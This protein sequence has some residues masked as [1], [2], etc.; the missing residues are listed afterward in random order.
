MATEDAISSVSHRVARPRLPSRRALARAASSHAAEMGTM[1][2]E[3]SLVSVATKMNSVAQIAA[4][5]RLRLP[6]MIRVNGVTA[7]KISKIW[8]SSGF[9]RV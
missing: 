2:T 3:V 7:A 8:S 4:S 1:I 6:L 5:T 9:D